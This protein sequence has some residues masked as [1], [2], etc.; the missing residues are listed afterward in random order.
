ML[1]FSVFLTMG[2]AMEEVRKWIVCMLVWISVDDDA[3]H[4]IFFLAAGSYVFWICCSVLKISWRNKMSNMTQRRNLTYN[5]SKAFL[6]TFGY[7]STYPI[8][9][10]YNPNILSS[11]FIS[12]IEMH[13]CMNKWT[14]MLEIHGWYNR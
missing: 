13:S 2:H 1:R 8:N 3:W 6:Y 7:S 10:I 9:Y 5:T 14:N 11:D 12:L 4:T